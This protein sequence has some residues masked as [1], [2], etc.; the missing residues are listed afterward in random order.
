MLSM[1]QWWE[2]G[3]HAGRMSAGM[4]VHREFWSV[5][6]SHSVDECGEGVTLVRAACNP[7][8][9]VTLPSRICSAPFSCKHAGEPYCVSNNA[10]SI[11]V[12]EECYVNEGWGGTQKDHLNMFH[13]H[14]F[15]EYLNLC[16]TPTNV[17]HVFQKAP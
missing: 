4:T 1:W 8:H 14:A 3:R 17:L 13:M 2:V 15:K 10:W 9:V 11:P 6:T 12:T 5:N 16:S 7:I